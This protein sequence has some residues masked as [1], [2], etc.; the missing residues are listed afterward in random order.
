MNEMLVQTYERKY[1]MTDAAA[2]CEDRQ[3]QA[4]VEILIQMEYAEIFSNILNKIL[5]EN[6]NSTY[7]V[8]NVN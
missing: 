7:C 2:F 3:L 1:L 8:A 4:Q 6:Y 5:N